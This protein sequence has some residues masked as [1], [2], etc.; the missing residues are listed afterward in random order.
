MSLTKKQLSILQHTLGADQYGNS[1]HERNIFG[2]HK[3]GEGGQICES[4]VSLGYMTSREGNQDIFPGETF[5]FAT[6][7]GKQAMQD[8][9][10]KP[11]KRTRGQERYAKYLRSELQMPFI[12]WLQSDYVNY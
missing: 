3:E 11:P 8:E 5:Y 1:R 9:S 10:P 12:D 2:T 6:K 7:T 4:L